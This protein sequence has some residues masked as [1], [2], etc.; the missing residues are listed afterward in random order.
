MIR[1]ASAVLFA[2]D[3]KQLTAFY[4]TALELPI[5]HSDAVHAVLDAGGFKL[6]V[7]QIP[8]PIASSISI[9]D[10]PQRR[11]ETAIRLNFIV[12][13]VEK[14]RELAARHRGAIDAAAPAW[15]SSSATIRLGYDPEGNVFA[16]DTQES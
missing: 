5:D 6:I 13:D 15:A 12:D 2:R 11:E 3:A 14:I 9:T 16:I 10:P 8:S 7:H 1:C 4:A